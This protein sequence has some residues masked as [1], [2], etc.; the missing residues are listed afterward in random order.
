MP[1]NFKSYQEKERRR[2]IALGIGTVG[3]IGLLANRRTRNAIIH[4]ALNNAEELSNRIARYAPATTFSTKVRADEFNALIRGQVYQS[5]KTAHIESK[6]NRGLLRYFTNNGLSRREAQDLSRRVTGSGAFGTF[7]GAR[8]NV[9]DVTPLFQDKE[10]VGLLGSRLKDPTSRRALASIFEDAMLSLSDRRTANS[11][12]L[13]HLAVSDSLKG[14]FYLSLRDK[15]F[16][17][18]SHPFFGLVRTLARRNNINIRPWASLDLGKASL[19]DLSANSRFAKEAQESI[20][21]YSG[22]NPNLVGRLRVDNIYSFDGKQYDLR[23]LFSAGKDLRDIFVNHFQVPLAP[24]ALGVNPMQLFPWLHGNLDR[25]YAFIGRHSRDPG[26]KGLLGKAGSGAIGVDVAKV[27]NDWLSYNPYELLKETRH[28]VDSYPGVDVEDLLLDVQTT[29][30]RHDFDAVI[31]AGDVGAIARSRKQV[32]R[33]LRAKEAPGN[34][35]IDSLLPD[36]E[37]GM[38]SKIRSVFTK[39]QE[40]SNWIVKVFQRIVDAKNPGDVSIE[41]VKRAAGILRS[42]KLSKNLFPVFLESNR[43]LLETT[44]GPDATDVLIKHGQSN[45]GIYAFYRSLTDYIN[46]PVVDPIYTSLE[47]QII[48]KKSKFLNQTFLSKFNAFQHGETTVLGRAEYANDPTNL[49][50]G[51]NISGQPDHKFGFDLLRDAVIAESIAQDAAQ[52]SNIL[53]NSRLY[54]SSSIFR[55][56]ELIRSSGTA[57]GLSAEAVRG[58]QKASQSEIEDAISIAYGNRLESALTVGNTR[59]TVEE[60]ARLSVDVIQRNAEI[61]NAFMHAV[62]SRASILSSFIE[63]ED[64]NLRTS[65]LAVKRGVSFLTELNKRLATPNSNAALATLSAA[66]AYVKQFASLFTGDQSQVTTNTLNTEFFVR[67]INDLLTD[68]EVPWFGKNGVKLANLG[69]TDKDLGSAW[70]IT[71]SIFQKRVLPIYAGVQAYR[72]LDYASDAFGLPGP[73]DAYASIRGGL[74]ELRASLFGQAIFGQRRDVFPGLDKWISD[75]NVEEEREHQRSG[76]E[77]VRKGRF[78][79]IGSR[80]P[81]Y[82]DKIDYYLPSAVNAARSNWA[83]AENTGISGHDYWAHSF[84]PNPNNLFLG[85]VSSLLGSSWF[86]RKY[87]RGDNPSRP[88]PVTGPLFDPNSLHGALLNPIVSPILKPQ[89]AM[90]PDYVPVNQGGRMTKAEALELN[91]ALKNPVNDRGLELILNPELGN[92]PGRA[93]TNVNTLRS[94]PGLINYAALGGNDIGPTLAYASG[95]GQMVLKNLPAASFNFQLFGNNGGGYGGGSYAGS[96]VGIDNPNNT[97][98]YLSK[99]H[100]ARL[101]KAMRSGYG[102]GTKVS[103]SRLKT[104]LA[105]APAYNEEDLDTLSSQSKFESLWKASTD[106]AGLY[107]WLAEK[108]IPTNSQSLIMTSSM[109]A[110]SA[111]QAFYE[112]SLGGI[113]GSLSEV[114]RRFIPRRGRRELW[115]PVPNTMPGWLPGEDYFINFQRG[116]PYRLIQRGLMRLPGEAY[117]RLHPDLRL[118]KSRASALGKS[119]EEMMQSM[120]YIGSP[121]SKRME[122]ITEL[123]TDIH[124]IMQQKWREMGVLLGAEREVYNEQYNISGHYDALLQ[125]SSGK[126]VTDIKTVSAKRFAEAMKNGA[127]PEHVAQLNFYLHELGIKRGFITYIN[128]DELLKTGNVSTFIAPVEYSNAEFTRNVVKVQEARARLNRLIDKGILHRGD[129]YDPITRFEILS[130]VAPYSQQAQSL[131]TYLTLQNKTGDLS[132]EENERFQAAKDRAT[133]TKKQLSLTPYRFRNVNIRKRSVV[134]ER[135]LDTNRILLEGSDTPIRLAGVKVSNERIRNLYGEPL[136]NDQSLAELL[137]SKYNIRKGSRITIGVEGDRDRINQDVLKTESAVIFSNGKN[138]N[139]EFLATGVGEEKKTAWSSPDVVARFTNSEIISGKVWEFLSHM[140]TPYHTKLLR[141]RS[142]LEELERGIVYGKRSGGW[143][144]PVRDYVIPSLESFVSK[145]PL[146]AA[147]GMAGFA[148]FFIRT[149]S[150]KKTTAIV[151]GIA[152]SV[153]STIRLANDTFRGAPWKPQRTRKRE[154]LEEYYDILKYIKYT[155]LAVHESDAAKKKEGI[156]VRKLLEKNKNL[157]K[158]RKKEVDQLRARKKE[159]ILLG[160]DI[161]AAEIDEINARI[162][163]LTSSRSYAKL[164]KHAT[165]AILYDQLAQSTLYAA[166]SGVT[167]FQSVYAAFPK[168]KRELLQGFIDDSSKAEQKRI[169]SLLPRHEKIAIGKTL[170]MPD[171]AIPSKLKLSEYFKKHPLPDTKWKGWDPAV[172][173]D[174]LHMLSIEKEGLDPMDSGYFQ[175]QVD[176]AASRHSTVP[177]PVLR[178]TSSRVRSN[179]ED[180]LNGKNMKDVRISVNTTRS[181]SERDSV[182]I[183]LNVVRNNEMELKRALGI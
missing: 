102:G 170:G 86:E 115:N 68:V 90:H 83:E 116:D 17:D 110:Q 70:D 3:V 33:S 55:N 12:R 14:Q 167:P 22:Y 15:A 139:Q 38:L 117:E 10:I 6:V 148:G 149:K 114:G 81:F 59:Y 112:M 29:L 65:E 120:L 43:A 176:E 174:D 39:Y 63:A 144:H 27:H 1:N 169:Y 171:S 109:D 125:T 48:A 122:S 20:D 147:L 64:E 11:I 175:L 75:R 67:R 44:F 154:E 89:A 87:S 18:T 25:D 85:P 130:D 151:A 54:T 69:V 35:T 143:D 82:G 137:Y 104:L 71:R 152:G 8:N 99:E 2:R 61:Q 49:G 155:S 97:F 94:T 30:T 113:G 76:Y 107:G 32:E 181:N 128:R 62:N 36:A 126:Q 163:A 121:M 95:S 96:G 180:I 91:R 157:G 105:Y 93:R 172:N 133:E 78:W 46:D 4:G 80:T 26:L 153:L 88:Y 146:L 34:S 103:A 79:L 119:V 74:G 98:T 7:A 178:T 159:L 9:A 124:E 145:N 50:L 28:L 118:M 72:Y 51:Y 101:N 58:V 138:I 37:S 177:L 56:I 129:L 142:P 156:D 158:K 19:N 111:S 66:S 134:V 13:A 108:V 160:A 165:K 92:V 60:S 179:L 164:G 21:A 173:L 140:D 77:P 84:L 100:L 41:D 24:H 5:I 42:P 182:D 132:V 183:N 161:N 162:K 57:T 47:E 73:S 31:K 16:E 52:S 131:K 168:Y 166:E 123:G 53:S 136:S 23:K 150:A 135:I 127:L 141:N 45:Q 106:V 40:D